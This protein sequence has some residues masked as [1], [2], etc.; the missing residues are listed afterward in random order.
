MAAPVANKVTQVVIKEIGKRL[1]KHAAKKAGSRV[2]GHVNR[3]SRAWSKAFKH[4]ASTDVD[5]VSNPKKL[6]EKTLNTK[7]VSAAIRSTPS[8]AMTWS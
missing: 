5:T 2:V 7:E 4:Y 8:P 3:G 1:S 6:G